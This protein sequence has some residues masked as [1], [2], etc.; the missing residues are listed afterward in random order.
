[1]SA[2]SFC[3]GSPAKMCHKHLRD[4]ETY[5]RWTQEPRWTKKMTT[6]PMQS[7]FGETLSQSVSTATVHE[8]ITTNLDGVVP[9]KAWG[10]TSYF[11]NP[12]ARFKRGTYF[13]TIKEKD[14][15]NDKGSSLDHD[16]IWRLNIGVQKNTFIE[17]FGPP[18]VRPAKGNT[19]TGPWDFTAIDT[20]MPHPVYGWMGWV[21]VLC[22]GATNWAICQ[23]LLGDAHRR[24]QMTFAKRAKT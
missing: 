11:Y 24:A 22:P 13:A 16:G 12:G 1:M 18:P 20:L 5:T 6:E 23:K 2:D 9:T 4:Q 17:L 3:Q 15:D 7:Q 14:G 8:H 10:E 21:A 19:I